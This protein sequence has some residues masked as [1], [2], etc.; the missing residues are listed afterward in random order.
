MINK[1]FRYDIALLR[2]IAVLSVVFYHLKFPFFSSGFIGVDIFFVISGYLMTKIIISGI[3]KN[4]FGLIDFY[5]KRLVRI[6][7]ALLVMITIFSFV[8]YFFLPIKLPNFFSNAFPS[9]LFYSNIYYYL[10]SGYFESSSQENF[11]LHS[12]SLSVEWQFY[13]IFPIILILFNKLGFRNYKILLALITIL[14]FACMYYY[15]INDKSFS[16]FMLPSRAWEMSLGGFGFL[17][18]KKAREIP[19][20]IRKVLVTCCYIILIIVLFRIIDI[21]G[22]SWPN[23]LTFI[24]AI[25]TL[26]IILCQV[27]FKF[28]RLV[29]I[30]FIGDISYSWYLWHWPIYVFAAYLMPDYSFKYQIMLLFITFVIA[31]ISYYLVERNNLFLNPK[32]I[33]TYTAV[34]AMFTL[35]FSTSFKYDDKTEFYRN[36]KTDVLPTQFNNNHQLE[37]LKF[38]IDTSAINNSIQDSQNILFL[39][40]SHTGMFSNFLIK[41]GKEKGINVV[42]ISAD[43]TFPCPNVSSKFENPEKLMNWIFNSFILNNRNKIDKIV[44]SANYSAYNNNDLLDKLKS[45]DEYFKSLNLEYILVGQTPIYKFE[46]PVISTLSRYDITDTQFMEP[47]VVEV[48]ELIKLNN[49]PYIDLLNIP[50]SKNDQINTYIYDRDHLSLYGAEQYSRHISNTIF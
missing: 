27:D 9:T 44:I 37:K 17:Y 47:R 23:K 32:L 42:Q 28:I 39:G 15:F 48:N 16:F 41:Q 11:L 2:A 21:N 12:W 34:L 46:Y 50:I 14:S 40:D 4:S 1:A 5:K 24:P 35:I 7:P 45:L 3:D 43:A 30:K 19:I 10:S 22:N 13:M 26:G 18:E 38:L 29:S 25:V 33:L 20:I 49:Y 6:F 8:L 31:I 36:Y